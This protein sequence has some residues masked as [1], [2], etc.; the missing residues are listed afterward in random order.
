[1]TTTMRWCFEEELAEAIII[2][3]MNFVVYS[4]SHFL[5]LIHSTTYVSITTFP[6][7]RIELVTSILTIGEHRELF[8]TT[9][10]PYIE[11][12]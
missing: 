12:N 4:I 11:L 6:R 10:L 8:W 5:V 2:F 7:I 3:S 9:L 1:M